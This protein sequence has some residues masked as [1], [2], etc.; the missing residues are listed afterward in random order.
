MDPLFIVRVAT[1]LS[2][3]FCFCV[4]SAGANPRIDP[5][6]T[7]NGACNGPT[8]KCQIFVTHGPAR[9]ETAYVFASW[10]SQSVGLAAIPLIDDCQ[11]HNTFKMLSGPDHAP[12]GALSTALFVT[13]VSTCSFTSLT[14]SLSAPVTGGFDAIF[15]QVVSISGLEPDSTDMSTLKAQ[16]GNGPSLNVTSGMPSVPNEMIWGIWLFDGPVTPY[17][18]GRGYTSVLTGEAVSLSEYK[19]ISEAAPQKATAASAAGA[20]WVAYAIGFKIRSD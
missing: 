10:W 11:Q 8:A 17:E 5:D 14:V 20:H 12:G 7:S 4:R 1:V 2:L 15:A 16:P 3:M 13:N 19:N 6:A 18:T 9:G